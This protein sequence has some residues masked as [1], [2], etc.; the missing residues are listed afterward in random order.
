MQ[1]ETTMT[2]DR[3]R[4]RLIASLGAFGLILILVVGGIKMLRH[5]P[6]A[7]AS[8]VEAA[9]KSGAEN[10]S[11]VGGDNVTSSASFDPYMDEYEYARRRESIALSAQYL[12][13]AI[14][15][16]GR[17]TYR[18]NLDSSITH[19]PRYNVLRHAGTMYAL[20]MYHDLTQ[21]NASKATLLSAGEFLRFQCISPIAQ[22]SGLLAVWSRPEL[23]HTDAPVQA[24][25]G[26]SGLGLVGLLSMEK[27]SPGTTSLEDLRGLGRFLLFMQKDD[28]SFYSKYIPSEGGRRDN[29]TSLYYPGEAALGLIM[30]HG[31]DDDS[32]WLRGATRAL[33]YL[34]RSREGADKVPADHWALLATARLLSQSRS[35][36]SKVEEGLLINHAIQICENIM[37]Q[38][39]SL[40]DSALL[41]GGF[42][43]DGRTTPTATRLE[44]LL[45]ALQIIPG[46]DKVIRDR[47]TNS[48]QRGMIFLTNAQVLSGE[49][50][51][52]MPRAIRQLPDDG[53]SKV[54][55]FNRR[56]TEVRIDYVQHAMSAMIQYI[57]A[58]GPQ[59]N[60]TAQAGN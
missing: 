20:G 6:A 13:G 2:K 4:F 59:P 23:N 57:D 38:Q 48:I 34:A 21:D 50:S 12:V 42:T 26:G 3:K 41:L 27:A 24:K 18:I 30:L 5:V 56:A 29:W 36:L 25:L 33:T 47:I 49:H 9:V 17:F 16:N 51:G 58:F 43:T 46:Q 11:P 10:S 55:N 8:S 39:V 32:R 15:D 28:G 52:A 14:E 22:E 7:E 19:K 53:T 54:K 37:N 45:A 44:G 31:H 35:E 60:R 1:S 40:T